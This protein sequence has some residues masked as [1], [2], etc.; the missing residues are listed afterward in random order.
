MRAWKDWLSPGREDGPM[1]LIWTPTNQYLCFASGLGVLGCSDARG[2][3]VVAVMVRVGVMARSRIG[4]PQA[5]SEAAAT[6][7]RISVTDQSE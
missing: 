3:A 1:I 4:V 7:T 2:F 5:V 6:P